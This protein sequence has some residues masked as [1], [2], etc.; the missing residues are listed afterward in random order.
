M[1]ETLS[2]LDDQQEEIEESTSTRLND[3]RLELAN[4]ASIRDQKIIKDLK[5]KKSNPEP[6]PKPP[7]KTSN[8]IENQA[9]VDPKQFGLGENI[10]E[11]GAAIGQGFK[12]AAD[13]TLTAPE[14]LFDAAKGEQIGDKDYRVEWDP[15]KDA[16]DPMAKT[17]WG[18]LIE[19]VTHY[20]A[21]GLGVTALSRGK[22]KGSQVAMVSA[23]IAALLSKKH[24]DQN[25]SGEIVKRV[26]EMN[27]ILGPLATKDTDHP[28]LKK[29]KNVVEE[30]GMTGILDKL[31]A[32]LFQG[33]GVEIEAA[34]QENVTKQ[35]VE[36]GKV[37]LKE[38]V[39]SVLKTG[40]DA[41]G[42][43]PKVKARGHM[44]KPIVDQH[45]GSPN[46]TGSAFSIVTQLKK[47]ADD[48]RAK[49]G[50][51]DSPLTPTQAALMANDSSLTEGYLKAAGREIFGDYRYAQRIK[52]AGGVSANFNEYF[53]P[54]LARYQ[55]MLGRN[56]G[57][58]DGEEF[59]KDFYKSATT[60]DRYMEVDKWSTEDML[61]ADMLNGA[62]FKQLRDLNIGIR[63]ID[64]VLDYKAVD[65]PI[66]SIVDRL[67][68]GLSEVKKKRLLWSVEGKSM[69]PKTGLPWTEP[70][71]KVAL[72][73]IGENVKNNIRM[74]ME[75]AAKDDNKEL[76][77]GLVE[78]MS[79]S[80]SINNWT[81]LDNF[82]RTKLWSFD[83]KN[84][85]LRELGSLYVNSV[86]SGVKTPIRAFIG[87]GN[88]GFLQ[89]LSKAIGAAA[90]LDMDS[91]RANIA[92]ITAFVDT[93]PEAYKVFKNQMEGYW[94]GD[95]AT[96]KN[97]YGE[98]TKNDEAWEALGK[99]S[100]T[101]GSAGDKAAFRI[102]NLTR[103]LND[104]RILS[105]SPRVMSSIDDTYKVIMARMRAKERATRK[106]LEMKKRGDITN[107]GPQ[108]Y[109][110]IEDE[111]Y[112]ELLDADGNIDLGKDK[113]L[114]NVFKDTTLTTELSGVSAKLDSAFNEFPI[115]KP[116]YLFARTGINGLNMT[117]K[118]APLLGA[119]HKRSLDVF[120]SSADDLSLVSKYGIL[121]ADDLANEKALITGRQIIGSGVT[122]MAVQKYMSD[123]I[124]GNGPQDRALRRSWIDAGYKP[125]SIKIGGVWMSYDT[126]EPFG[127]I[128]A[129]IADIGDNSE[130]MGQEWTEDKFLKIG[131][132]VA[133]SATSKSYLAGISDLV[134]LVS[135]EPGKGNRILANFINNSVPL[136]GLRNDFGRIVTP[137]MRELNSGIGDSIRNRNLFAEQIAGEPLGIKYDILNGKPLK[138]W[139]F[140]QRLVN[141][142]L[143]FNFSIDEMTPGRRLFLDSNFDSR[144]SIMSAG[145]Y[146][147]GDSAQVRSLY[148]K[149]LGEQNLEAKLNELAARK[150]V[151]SSMQDMERDRLNNREGRDPMIAYMHNTKIGQIFSEAKSRAWASIQSEPLVEQLVAEQDG[152]KL[153]NIQARNSQVKPLQ[154]ILSINNYDN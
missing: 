145:G 37:E 98:V 17:W 21:F 120:R 123:E 153:D 86:L 151:Q 44:N 31:F 10:V 19:N 129:S 80:N 119:L 76:L 20:G 112:G 64:S 4:Q 12:S 87:T 35:I 90:R 25:L 51:T 99:W 36:K 125:R 93:L 132:A 128:L 39:E 105:W 83:N 81:D 54:A 89:P 62:L 74:T 97:R 122:F 137:Y 60:T 139:N 149:A 58:I 100:E 115:I 68:V 59:F 101:R 148:M 102:A 66:T 118:S 79:M 116:F 135:M 48:Y 33:K 110:K 56:V 2:D 55:E 43:A 124:T 84:V 75:L 34:R 24:D 150:D 14:R 144:V 111:F 3:E 57:D 140:A 126:F 117:W 121:T 47:I 136:A 63:E 67:I 92:G 103:G 134:D 41:T 133:G 22:L 106:M 130:L 141:S 107:Y 95:I 146:D 88:V 127:T 73:D 69:N 104:T 147:L 78:I 77:D 152:I 18:G 5:A 108:D 96:M 109:K 38:S 1:E 71:L 138:D 23:G 46:S 13:S 114:D 16:P 30:V 40:D 70:E 6:E 154:D 8:P 26:P 91:A 85:A 143:P 32:K 15:L 131:L 65:G 94:S 50:G 52:E 29:L 113:F 72:A 27:Y 28:M 7:E 42:S 142:V 53:R 45:Q 11:V 9:T 49:T 82:M 61:A